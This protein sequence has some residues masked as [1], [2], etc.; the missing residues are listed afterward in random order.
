MVIFRWI[1]T[2]MNRLY[3]DGKVTCNDALTHWGRVT[4]ICVSILTNIGSYN[5]LSTLSPGRRKAITWTNVG[6]LLIR[7]LGTNFNEMLIEMLTFSFMKMRLKV[8]SAKWCPFCPG[9]NVLITVFSPRSV[10]LMKQHAT[11]YYPQ[12]IGNDNETLCYMSGVHE[13]SRITRNKIIWEA[14]TIAL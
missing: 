11:T 12:P 14:A 10:L 1:I 6:I 4:H 3:P 7:P 9:L 13:H 5:G 8:S 2:K